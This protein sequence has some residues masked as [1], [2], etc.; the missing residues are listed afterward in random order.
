LRAK[1]IRDIQFADDLAIAEW[2]LFNAL[3]VAEEHLPSEHPAAL[4]LLC[5]LARLLYSQKRYEELTHY[6]IH[7]GKS[8]LR[9]RFLVTRCL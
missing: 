7:F 5:N 1:I 6:A 2:E 9:F 3:L 4:V 8:F